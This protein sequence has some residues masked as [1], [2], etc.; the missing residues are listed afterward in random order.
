MPPSRSA[1]FLLSIVCL[2]LAAC[3]AS[4]TAAPTSGCLRDPRSQS[5]GDRDDDTQCDAAADQY[6]LPN[7]N[8][9]AHRHPAAAFAGYAGYRRA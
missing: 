5:D 4:P 9:H 8:C 3:S 7:P 6:P 2:M 1:V